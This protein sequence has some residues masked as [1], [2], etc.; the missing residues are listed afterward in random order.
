MRGFVVWVFAVAIAA[1]A[2]GG[3]GA[4]QVIDPVARAA[5][6]TASTPGYQTSAVMSISGAGAPVTARIKGAVDTATNTGTMNVS[7]VIAGQSIDAAMVFSRLNF[8][9]RSAAIP[10][11]ASYTG[12]KPWIYVDMTKT[13]AAMG[14]G[15]L[16]ATTDPTQFL[17]YLGAVGAN[18]TVV[19]PVTIN[20]VSTTEYRAVV[21]LDH[22]ATLYHASAQTVSALE[23][24]LGSHTMPVQAWIDS[25]HRVRRIHVAFPECVGGS[26]VQFSMTMGIYGFGAQPPAQIPARSQVYNLT[27]ALV[28]RY[29]NVKLGCA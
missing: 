21:N 23:T 25:E 1:V 28:A 17:H 15:S 22:Y 5:A 11:A 8:W 24:A 18:P 14:L 3:C 26:T 19:G 27:K 2:V 10:G 6:V 16:P 9:M 12:G 13:L 29:A 20:G 4:S 7:E